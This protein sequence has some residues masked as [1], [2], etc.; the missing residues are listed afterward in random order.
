MDNIKT[1]SF[2]GM[3]CLG[4]MYGNIMAENIGSENVSFI[5]GEERF[6]RHTEDRYM[7]NGEEK[8][9]Q[10]RAG[11]DVKPADLVVFA[12]K[13]N[14]L[15]DAMKLAEPAVSDDTIIVS[16]LNGISSEAVL[17]ETFDRE[18]IVDSICLGM[19]CVRNGTEILYTKTG[20]WEV[21]GR[22]E[23][24]KERARQVKDFCD[25]AGVSCIIP[26]D[27]DH[28]M[29]NK[30]MINVGINQ[31]CMVHNTTYGVARGGSPAYDDLVAAMR[32][33]ILLAPYEG[34][35]LSE[36]DLEKNI[37][38]LA[39]LD[40]DKYPSM[41]QDALARRRSEVELFAG[42]MIRLAE[43]HGIEVPVNRRYYEEIRKREES[44]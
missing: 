20:H 5:M 4:I 38:L 23:I 8:S 9:F 28:A 16:L 31:T 35:N 7:V 32:E 12:I 15:E 19:D 13:F 40:K 3:G 41:Q 17:A 21:G 37:A 36:E 1:V 39:A 14:D 27:I 10:M 6:R 43:K 18:Q 42:T 22:S 33:V 26:E 24:Q 44:Y 34:V 30:F 2:V 29:W 25:R 11:D